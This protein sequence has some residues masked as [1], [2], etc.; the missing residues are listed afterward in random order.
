MQTG[1]NGVNLYYEREGSGKP[2]LV[3]HGWGASVEAVRPIMNCLV[4]MG[5]EAVAFDFPGMGKS[6]APKTAWGVP[7]YAALTGAFMKE[8]G[9]WGCDVVCHSFGGR[10]VIYLSTQDE[11]AFNKLVLVDA[12]GIQRKRTIRYHMKTWNYKLGKR[13]SKIAFLDALFHIKERQKNAG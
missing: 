13:L 3:L 6:G 2:V 4:R 10:V 1:I 5:R 9:I 12:A 8:Q 11:T 7:E